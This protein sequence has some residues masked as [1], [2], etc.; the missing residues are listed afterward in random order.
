MGLRAELQEALPDMFDAAGED[1]IFTPATGV[2]IPCKVF[3]DFGVLFQPSGFDVQVWERGTKIEALLNG[4]GSIPD[5]IAISRE[6][7]SGET[8][9]LTDIGETYTVKAILENDGFTVK[10]VVT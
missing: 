10:A 2:P 8:F 3:I 9:A 6:P 1:A 7:A 4:D 5:G